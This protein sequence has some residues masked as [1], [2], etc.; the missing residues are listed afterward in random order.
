MRIHGAVEPYL[1][2]E[3]ISYQLQAGYSGVNASASQQY[4]RVP[5][6]YLRGIIVELWAMFPEIRGPELLEDLYGLEISICT[7]NARRVQLSELLSRNFMRHLLWYFPWT[8]E[9]YKD[10]YFKALESSCFS[11]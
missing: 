11:K 8:K 2:N 5:G 7:K 1:Y 3:S 9:G 4:K 6:R 10:E